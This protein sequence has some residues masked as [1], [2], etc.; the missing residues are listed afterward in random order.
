[1]NDEELRSVLNSCDKRIE[2]RF[3]DVPPNEAGIPEDV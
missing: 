1:M 2:I 3:L